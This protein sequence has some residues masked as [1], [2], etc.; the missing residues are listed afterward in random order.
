MA[1]AGAGGA[2]VHYSGLTVGAGA[3]TCDPYAAVDEVGVAPSPTE[4]EYE[5]NADINEPEV[6]VQNELAFENDENVLGDAIQEIFD[7]PRYED[8]KDRHLVLELDHTEL[9]NVTNA[10]VGANQA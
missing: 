9:K 10:L 2:G 3:W 6:Y 5:K 1:G 4:I 8:D 7:P